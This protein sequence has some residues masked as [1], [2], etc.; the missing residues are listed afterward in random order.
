M[1]ISVG[2]RPPKWE[3]PEI[4]QQ[5]VDEFFDLI[6]KGEE[7]PSVVGLACYLGVHKQTLLN[8][9]EKDDYKDIVNTAKQRIEKMFTARAYSGQIPAPIFIFTAKNHYDYKDSQDLNHGGQAGNPV[10]TETTIVLSPEEAYRKL[11]DGDD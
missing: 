1:V 8:Y 11:L 3:S 9:Q 10:K 6:N 5:K 7:M 2:G 4:L